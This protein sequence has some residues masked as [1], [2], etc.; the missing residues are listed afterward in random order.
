[1]TLPKVAKGKKAVK[2]RLKDEIVAITVNKKS[3][4]MNGGSRLNYQFFLGAV[5]GLFAVCE[6]VFGLNDPYHL[7]AKN[8]V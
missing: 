7:R 4:Q 1:M 2:I 3:D 8:N 6:D 5:G